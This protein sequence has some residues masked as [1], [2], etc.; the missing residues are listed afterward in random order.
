MRFGPGCRNQ[1][2]RSPIEA[3]EYRTAEPAPLEGY[4][5]VGEIAAGVE[6][7]QPRFNRR[8]VHLYR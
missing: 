1:F 7:R 4:D 6:H 3:G 5:A 2:G 8:S